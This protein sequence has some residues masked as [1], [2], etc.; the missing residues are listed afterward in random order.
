MDLGAGTGDWSIR[1]A[2]EF[3]LSSFDG[4]DPDSTAIAKGTMQIEEL[5]LSNVKM[6]VQDAESMEY[7][8]DFDIA[9]LGEVL[10]LIRPR[11]EVLRACYRALREG[12]LL[13]ICEGLASGKKDMRRIE[14][15]LV[16]A[17]Q[18]DF[19]LQGGRFY[20]KSELARLL[21]KT[22]F[23]SVH[24]HDVGGGL[25]FVIA[26]KLRDHHKG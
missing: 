14:N 21:S 24:F 18:L 23:G 6:R 2:R 20:T 3:P 17:M 25:W 7:S 19:A 4:I 16:H 1:L 13:V 10:Y 11:D 22:G 15:Q 5:G 26:R 8:G 12:G 9:H